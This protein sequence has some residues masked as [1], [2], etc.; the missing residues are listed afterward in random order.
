MIKNLIPNLRIIG[1]EVVSNFL[2][3]EN[4]YILKKGNKEYVGKHIKFSGRISIS[5]TKDAYIK[6]LSVNSNCIVTIKH[7]IDLEDELFIVM[8]YVNWITLNKYMKEIYFK[9]S[10]KNMEKLKYIFSNIA[11]AIDSVHS[12]NLVHADIT[13]SNILISKN[14]EIKIIDFDFAILDLKI[15]KSIDVL[16]YHSLIFEFIFEQIYLSEKYDLFVSDVEKKEHFSKIAL[17]HKTF[18][19]CSDVYSNIFGVN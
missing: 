19:S 16:K 10:D 11:K 2:N 17:Q 15:S 9:E 1:I 8:E 5:A 3:L 13:G 18:T 14:L 4:F 7:V 6:L 12:Y